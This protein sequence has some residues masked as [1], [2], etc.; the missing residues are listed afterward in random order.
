RD[1]HAVALAIEPDTAEFEL[2]SGWVTSVN[3]VLAAE[4]ILLDVT[5]SESELLADMAKKTRQYIRK[6][7]ADVTIKQVKKREEI[8][9]CLEVYRQTAAR[10]GF[11]LH[12]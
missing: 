3:K 4:T 9:A 10:A 8:E 2:P 1:H 5:K 12:A 7:G 6:S 11:N